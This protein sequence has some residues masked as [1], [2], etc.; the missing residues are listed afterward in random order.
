LLIAFVVPAAT[1]N[2][3]IS[4]VAYGATVFVAMRLVV[5]P[6]SA[7]PRSVTFP[8]VATALDLV[9]HMVL[10]AGPIVWAISRELGPPPH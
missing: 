6:L 8:P 2:I 3:G 9:S 10:F 7:Y 5:L 1:R 4:A